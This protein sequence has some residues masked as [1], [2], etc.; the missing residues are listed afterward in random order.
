MWY[1]TKIQI[2]LRTKH[3]LKKKELSRAMTSNSHLRAHLVRFA[4][5]EFT[6]PDYF[7]TYISI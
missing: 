1:S 3:N 4:E 6:R 7:S 5:V 2:F